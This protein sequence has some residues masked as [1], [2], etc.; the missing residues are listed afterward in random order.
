MNWTLRSNF[1]A[2]KMDA[3]E[4]LKNLLKNRGYATKKEIDEFLNP[5]LEKVT[6]KNVGIESH[7][8]KKAVDLIKKTIKENKAIIIYG[9][10]DVDGITGTAILWES[11]YSLY[12]NTHPYIPHRIDEGYGLSKKG[13]QNLEATVQDIGLIITVDNGIVASS[14]VEYA[15]SLG[16]QVIIT[17]HHIKGVTLPKAD[18]IVHTTELC[19]AGV[20]YLLS[21]EIA[22]QDQHLELVA[23]AT[24]ADLVSLNIYNRTLVKFG[25]EKLKKTKRFRCKSD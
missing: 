15:K 3:S 10:Y 23:L 1:S 18:A 19:G 2:K 6:V 7:E 20:G 13:I 14:A 21:K 24:I 16:I 8:I 17:D 9:D 11:L 25:L 12:K 4:I 22:K 5:K